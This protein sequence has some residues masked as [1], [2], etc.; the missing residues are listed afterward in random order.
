MASSLVNK[1]IKAEKQSVFLLIAKKNDGSATQI[2]NAS[3]SL[4][5]SALSTHPDYVFI[6][7][8]SL[9]GRPDDIE[10]FIET[11]QDINPTLLSLYNDTKNDTVTPDNYYKST[12]IAVEKITPN[13][14]QVGVDRVLSYKKSRE[15]IMA[16]FKSKNSA[17]K[18]SKISDKDK[19]YI[20]IE[21]IDS[22]ISLLERNFFSAETKSGT[23]KP[24]NGVAIT[25]PTK[26]T[27]VQRMK[28]AA[29]NNKWLDVT[30][31]DVNGAGIQTK[32][33]KPLHAFIFVGVPELERCYFQPKTDMAEGSPTRGKKYVG[34]RH[35]LKWYSDN[36]NG[37][38]SF[39]TSDIDYI[40]KNSLF[41]CKQ[42]SEAEKLKRRA[43]QEKNRK[44]F[45]AKKKARS[46]LPM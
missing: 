12:V 5:E 1:I 13:V 34:P 37:Q 30:S 20:P 45:D 8:V 39:S 11:T 15:E 43:E 6:P 33:D 24:P 22:L 10:T 14:D 21:K 38:K 9:A 42:R 29:L 25:E 3:F 28:E 7:S 2:K 40:M 18:V 44:E 46:E 26:R 16:Y 32:K 4:T 27:L 17:N 41:T 23:S 19:S 36:V 31:C 35:F